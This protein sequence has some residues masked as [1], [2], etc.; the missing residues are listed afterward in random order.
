L[1]Y[2]LTWD[3]AEHFARECGNFGALVRQSKNMFDESA[4][5]DRIDHRSALA[6][7]MMCVMDADLQPGK[8]NNTSRRAQIHLDADKVVN[9]ASRSGGLQ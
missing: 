8:T 4:R 6:L 3:R 1:G 5:K 9:V 2:S 7:I